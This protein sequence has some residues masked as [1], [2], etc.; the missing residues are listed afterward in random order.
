MTSNTFGL[1]GICNEKNLSTD[2]HN[3][4]NMIEVSGKL[5]LT[6]NVYSLNTF[7]Q[8]WIEVL[9]PCIISFLLPSFH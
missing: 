8:L 9:F 3:R 1:E 6:R 2:L 4:I 7:Q 5:T